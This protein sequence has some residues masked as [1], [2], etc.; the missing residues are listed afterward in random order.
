MGGKVEFEI[1]GTNLVGVLNR[2]GKSAK[3][4]N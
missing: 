1:K 4:S 2:A 3:Y